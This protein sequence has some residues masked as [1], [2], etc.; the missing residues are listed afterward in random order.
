MKIAPLPIDEKKRLEALKQYDILDTEPE[1]IFENVVNLATYICNTPVAAISLV[2]EQRQ[3]F[4][5]VKGVDMKETPRDISFCSHAILQD[6]PLIIRNTLVDER[7]FDNPLVTGELGVRFYAGVPLVTSE[8]CNIGTLCVIDTIV[9]DIDEHQINAM[10]T[11]AQSI[12]AHLDLS[13]SHK[14]IKKYMDELQLAATI[15]ESAGESIVLTDHKN[16]IITVNPAFSEITGYSIQEVVG[17]NPK[18]LSSGRQNK[19]FYKTM[20]ASLKQNGR[21]SGELWNKR[22]D[23]VEYAQWLSIQVIYNADGSVR[24]YMAIF[25]D[26]TDRKLADEVIW[27]QANYDHL[28]N[29]PNRKLF[30][31]LLENQLRLSK[32][33]QALF[34]LLYVDLDMFKQVNDNFGH[35]YGDLL[36]EK[37]AYRLCSAIRESDIVSRI[38][39][40]EFTIILT[41][42]REISDVQ[43][44]VNNINESMKHPFELRDIV[45]N[46]SA[47]VGVAIYP[48][49][50]ENSEKL[51][52]HSDKRMYESK[53]KKLKKS[54]QF[55]D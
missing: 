6:E 29:L 3:W 20:W 53:T 36:L 28:T 43:K 46:I 9:R 5:A 44:I 23:G 33:S 21:W 35:E 45:V 51:M 41:N 11:L 47:S 18:F 27:R 34:A 48:D 50:G 37:A 10:Q 4:K 26:I 25:S 32:R 19:I 42:I 13:L 2:D 16:N 52:R 38:G 12:M 22:K 40:D 30:N 17:K 14:K 31:E 54:E 1:S 39:G 8:G 49:H 7:F 15:F 24:M 55:V